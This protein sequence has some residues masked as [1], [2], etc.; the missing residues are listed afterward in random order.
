MASFNDTVIE[1]FRANDGVLG[2]PWEGKDVVLL[3]SVGRRS[4]KQYVSPLVAAPDGDSFLV[5]ASQGG[6]PKDPE[7]VANLEAAT[8][9]ATLEI[10]TETVQADYRVVRPG[11]EGWAGLYGIWREYWP[12]A[13]EYEQKTDRQFPMVRM[14]VRR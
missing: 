3:H 5:C 8:G 2:G 1:N 9:P 6:A 12:G 13:A 7:W 10:G 14:T 4:G 11:D